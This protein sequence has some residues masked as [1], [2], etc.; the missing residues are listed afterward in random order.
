MPVSVT[1]ASIQSLLAI[2]V[3]NSTIPEINVAK[4][5][6][7]ALSQILVIILL[8]PSAMR[9]SAIAPSWPDN[10]PPPFPHF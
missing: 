1:S 2:E 4:V 5:V 3:T 6:D 9:K 8:L 10:P 7:I